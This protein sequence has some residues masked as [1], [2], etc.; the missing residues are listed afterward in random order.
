MTHVFGKI[1]DMLFRCDIPFNYKGCEEVAIEDITLK[2]MGEDL[3]KVVFENEEG[4]WIEMT[5]DAIYD[6]LVRLEM[7]HEDLLASF[8]FKQDLGI[9]DIQE[10]LGDFL[11]TDL[12]VIIDFSN[13][14]SIR[15]TN[16]DITVV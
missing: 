4:K 1:I 13:D 16:G 11:G 5:P 15:I 14:G 10:N 12:K 9:E 6:A 2:V 8:A 7:I 3:V